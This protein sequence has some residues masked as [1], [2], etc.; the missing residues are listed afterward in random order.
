MTYSI[1]L[2]GP[3]LS[4][5]RATEGPLLILAGAGTGKTRV[6]TSRIAHLVREGVPAS[7]ILAL[8]FTNKAA[9]EMHERVNSMVDASDSSG[10]TIST[11]HALCVRILRREAHRVG[12]KSN[13]S[14]YDEGD[15]LSVIRKI[16]PRESGP[17]NKLEP[18]RVR[19]FISDTKNRSW[20]FAPSGDELF[21]HVF[22]RYQE[23]LKNCNAMDFDDL[24]CFTAR[25]FTEVE[26]ARIKWQRRF[27]FIMV[28]EFQ[29]TNTL[30]LDIV[31]LLSDE[32]RNVCVVGDD[33]QSI[34]SWRGA[35]IRNILE[36]DRY[37]AKPKIVKLEQ[38]YR[39]TNAILG[40]ANSIIQRNP[41]RQPKALWSENGAGEK[42][43]LVEIPDDLEEAQYVIDEI[44]EGHRSAGAK[45]SDFAVLFRMNAQSRLFEEQLRRARIPYRIVGGRSFFDRRE[46]KDL[47]AYLTCLVNR[48]DDISLLRIINTPARGIGLS[49]IDLAVQEGSRTKTSLYQVLRSNRFLDGLSKRARS[50]IVKFTELIDLYETR[51]GAPLANFSVVLSD[52]LSEIGYN[53][54]VRQGCK[55]PEEAANRGQNVAE[56][57]RALS[58]YQSRDAGDGIS[59]FLS[60]ISLDQD[61]NEE[62]TEEDAV[63]LITF[64]AAKGLEFKHVFLIGVEEGLIPHERCRVERNL[65]EERR[66][67]YVG[68]TRAMRKLTITY[69][70]QRLMY[71]RP[72]YNNRSSFLEDMDPKFVEEID[73]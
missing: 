64:H 39:S 66:L 5:V 49:T 68:I 60:E 11:F 58:E 65:D 38:N 52:I 29:D 61:L 28:D 30:Q 27:A 10:I 35:E 46:I 22:E 69:C 18:G 4:A 71:G 26:E 42:V 36:F 3:Q 37:F 24:L 21:D 33:D 8:T 63:T 31:R 62:E 12:Y 7:R 54:G 6:I 15:S 19:T 50:A 25:L 1:K 47:L 56:L 16:I 13:F 17:G 44:S 40:T 73:F 72:S 59:G 34:Y 23:G 51:L 14:I 43:R 70:R 45:W 48:D 57:V 67:F 55:S 9:R 53:E 2:N 20:K 32:H 41:R